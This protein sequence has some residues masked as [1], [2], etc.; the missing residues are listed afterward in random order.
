[1]DQDVIR[2]IK[3]FYH[4][5]TVRKYIDA[6]DKGKSAPNFNILDSMVMLTGAWDIE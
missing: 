5:A 3:A 1:M 6:L 2:S 4:G